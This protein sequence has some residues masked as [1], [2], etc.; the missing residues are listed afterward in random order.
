MARILIIDDDDQFRIM[1]RKILEKAGYN[2]IKEA[3]N[4][5]T[6]MKIFRQHPFDLV[7]TDIIMPDK[8]GIEMITELTRD[9]PNIKII[10]MSGGGR[11]GPQGYLEMAE[12]LGASRTLAKPFKHSDL[13]AAVQEILNE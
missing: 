12:H 9:Y 10:A 6:G 7:I 8:E 1:L 5:S 13:I 11:I 2:S 4:G 3:A